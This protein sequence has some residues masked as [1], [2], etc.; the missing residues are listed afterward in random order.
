MIVD[1]GKYYLYR[2]IRLDN[3][4][5][6]YIG[7]G[8]KTKEDLK[9]GYYLRAVSK[10]YRNRIWAAIVEK[11]VYEVEILAESDDRDFIQKKEIE[12]IALYG[13]IDLKAGTLA[14]LT[15]GGDNGLNRSKLAV[16]KQ[17][18]TAK[19]NGTYQEMC[20][21][22]RFFSTKKGQ[23]GSSVNKRTFL[24]STSGHFIKDFSSRKEC[25]DYIASTLEEIISCIRKKQSH[26]GFVFSDCFEGE[27]ID[28]SNY[29][30][31]QIKNKTI[32]RI[33]P[34]GTILLNK[35][36]SMIEA[37]IDINGRK[38]NM[39]TSMK[40]GHRYKG[41]YWAYENNV[42][43]FLVINKNKKYGCHPL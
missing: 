27:T 5:P 37:C 16:E 19:R 35:Y 32:F 28:L 21:R 7:I 41:N 3:G 14:N 8:K 22:M 43:D 20:N 2:H 25:A 9:Y 40:K 36:N 10:K 29:K 38:E 6:F 18:E 17:L 30:I 4:L 33:S 12:F 1:N 11:V 15:D 31:R 42:D 23:V 34:D 26:K 39:N 24:Y 13:R